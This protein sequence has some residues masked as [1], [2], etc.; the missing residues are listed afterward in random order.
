[1]QVCA[2]LESSHGERLEIRAGSG[3]AEIDI[4]RDAATSLCLDSGRARR[5]ARLLLK[6]ADQ[7][8]YARLPNRICG[9]RWTALRA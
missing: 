7:S 8:R 1:M 5:L 2:I 4:P 6:A 9:R 3:T